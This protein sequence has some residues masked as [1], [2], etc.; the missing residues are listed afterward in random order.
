M[1]STTI[2]KTSTVRCLG[3]A[4]ALMS[5]V[6]LANQP[7]QKDIDQMR[8][9]VVANFDAQSRE[10]IEAVIATISPKGQQMAG[11]TEMAELREESLK[12]IK[13]FTIKS[14]E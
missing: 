6:S 4:L 3:V 12:L 9:A 13:Y 8:D 10:D 5:T 2:A 14:P 1:K 7:T 11:P